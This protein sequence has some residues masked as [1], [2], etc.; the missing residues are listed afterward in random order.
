MNN[1]AKKLLIKYREGECT[2]EEIAIIESW[3]LDVKEE[4]I[5][6]SLEELDM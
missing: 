1:E 2:P 4:D 6:L 5:A 3:Y